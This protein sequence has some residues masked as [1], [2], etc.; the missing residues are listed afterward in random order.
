MMSMSQLDDDIARIA[1]LRGR[2]ADA[3][4]L[5]AEQARG[6]RRIAWAQVDMLFSAPADPE[7]DMLAYD[8][9]PEALRDC[10]RR[11]PTLKPMNATAALSLLEAGKSVDAIIGAVQQRLSATA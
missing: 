11:A 8:E 6:D 10:F 9:L 4:A 5:I 2:G 1:A 7:R 3:P